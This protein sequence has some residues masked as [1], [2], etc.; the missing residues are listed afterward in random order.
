MGK[1]KGGLGA[2][3]AT[4]GKQ[5]V[6]P[7]TLTM[8]SFLLKAAS[9]LDKE[10]ETINKRISESP[11]T[12][13]TVLGP[14]QGLEFLTASTV[15]VELASG[16]QCTQSIRGTENDPTDVD[17]IASGIHSSVN[18]GNPDLTSVIPLSPEIIVCSKSG[19]GIAHMES[20][21]KIDSPRNGENLTLETPLILNS[22]ETSVVKQGRGSTKRKLTSSGGHA[23]KVK[24]TEDV[25]S[26]V[27]TIGQL[28]P[29][30]SDFVPDLIA[31]FQIQLEKVLAEKL[32]PIIDKLN[33]ME[34]ALCLYND[35]A[36]S[37]VDGKSSS[38]PLARCNSCNTVPLIQSI[39]SGNQIQYSN[40]P[41]SHSSH[42]ISSRIVQHGRP[43]ITKASGTSPVGGGLGGKDEPVNLI[44]VST[45]ASLFNAVDTKVNQPVINLPPQ[46]SPYVLVLVNVPPLQNGTREDFQQLRNKSLHWLSSNSSLGSRVASNI[47][48]ARRVGWI[49]DGCKRARGNCVIV[50]FNN[51]HIA[52]RLLSDISHRPSNMS[53]SVIKALPLDYFY[54]HT[55]RS[56]SN[57]AGPFS[58]VQSGQ[59]GDSQRGFLNN[60]PLVSPAPNLNLCTQGFSPFLQ[61]R[62]A[63]RSGL[64]SCD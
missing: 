61:N 1:A 30:A 23:K 13:D 9:V 18:L 11:L 27:A 2:N 24:I 52:G 60:C 53:G 19:A 38:T 14:C 20:M 34:K 44:N 37:L 57:R 56:L 29:S 41:L 40:L 16:L 48:M 58:V 4:K 63:P 32:N 8:D 43:E 6:P 47:I 49:G 33:N 46:S 22:R 21:K 59:L 50:N 17:E 10:I 42:P 3:P 54:T 12:V 64:E 45:T 39:K 62:F 35:N 55:A 51:P 25:S 5:S 36:R 28:K 31:A 7:I 15:A 26:G